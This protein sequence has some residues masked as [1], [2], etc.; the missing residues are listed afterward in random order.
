MDGWNAG[1]LE[2]PQDLRLFQK[3]L[4]QTGLILVCFAQHLDGQGAVEGVILGAQDDAHAAAADLALEVITAHLG[5]QTI[6][7]GEWR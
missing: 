3:P 2:L 4:L 1:V 7:K 6:S 5:W